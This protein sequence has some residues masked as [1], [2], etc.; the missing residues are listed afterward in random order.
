MRHRHDWEELFLIAFYSAI[1]WLVWKIG[2]FFVTAV[3]GKFR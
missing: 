1:A 3:K 2:K